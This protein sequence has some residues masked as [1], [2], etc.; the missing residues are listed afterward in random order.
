LEEE[1]PLPAP[2]HRHDAPRDQLNPIF[3]LTAIFFLSMLSRLGMAPLLPAIEIELGMGHAQAGGLFLFI[4]A[5]YCTGLFGSIFLTPRFSHRSLIVL[6]GLSV[7]ICLL[8]AAVSQGLL[9][10]R[11]G[12][13]V[14]GLAGGIYLPSGVATLTALVRKADWGKV[15]GFHQLAPNLAYVTAPLAAEAVLAWRSW[16][17]VLVLYGAASLL[18]SL[19]YACW[20]RGSAGRSDPAQMISLGTVVRQP[21]IWLI[22]FLFVMGMGLNQGV[23]AVMPLYLNFERG[24]DHGWSNTILAIS[25][26]AAFAIPLAGG[27]L[28]D[29]YGV[30]RVMF[31][32]LLCAVAGT[33]ATVWLTNPWLWLA[34]ILQ[35]CASVSIFPLCFTMISQMTP[36]QTRAVAVSVVVPVA[37]LLGAGMVPLG[38]GM[39]A[40]AGRFDL[41]FIALATL[42]ALTLPGVLI[43]SKR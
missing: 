24:L 28:A 36:P 26:V 21:A 40:E 14:L 43:Y 11:L 8:L 23:F 13:M 3:F 9:L 7:G 17:M 10:L 32:T 18:L 16:R 27:W 25:R 15:L 6:S 4:S 22:T 12:L 31:T 38:I 30:R 19:G 5:G 41:G 37:H 42:T 2:H 34:L 39:L 20:G 29:R 1:D 35:A 33:F